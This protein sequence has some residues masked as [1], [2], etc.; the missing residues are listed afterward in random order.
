MSSLYASFMLIR[1]IYFAFSKSAYVQFRSGLSPGP[2][3]HDA[4]KESKEAKGKEP[5]P[6]SRGYDVDCPQNCKIWLRHGEE[7]YGESNW[8]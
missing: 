7:G 1:L 8:C 3:I 4:S 5:V 2:W 6:P